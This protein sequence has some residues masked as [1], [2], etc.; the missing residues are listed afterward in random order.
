MSYFFVVKKSAKAATRV[1]FT[2]EEDGRCNLLHRQVSDGRCLASA[3]WTMLIINK[4][5]F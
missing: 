4:Y 3:C 2:W 1:I 5:L